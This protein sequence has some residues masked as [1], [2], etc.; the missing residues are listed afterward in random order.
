MRLVEDAR[1]ENWVQADIARKAVKRAEQAEAEAAEME[2]LL[3]LSLR[4]GINA[5]A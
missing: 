5:V 2:R 1:H 3:N 4:S